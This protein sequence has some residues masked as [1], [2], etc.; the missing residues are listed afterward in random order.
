MQNGGGGGKSAPSKKQKPS[1]LIESKEYTIP[2]NQSISIADELRKLA[3]LK[4]EGILTE[5]E[6]KQ[7]KQ[8]L[9]RKNR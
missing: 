4:E 9:I 2:F 5:E 6:F 8:D 3:K 7:M 1:E